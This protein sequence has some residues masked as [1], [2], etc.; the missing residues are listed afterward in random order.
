MAIFGRRLITLK[1]PLSVN[2]CAENLAMAINK[3]SLFFAN[4][5]GTQPVIGTIHEHKFRIRKRR[6]YQNSFAP[7]F[8]GTL[9]DDMT[10]TLIEGHFSMHPVVKGFLIFWFA[11]VTYAIIGGIQGIA[12]VLTDLINFVS[13]KGIAHSYAG[14]P[15]LAFMLLGGIGVILIGQL[16]G[17]SEKKYLQEFLERTLKAHQINANDFNQ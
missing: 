10:G 9:H 15:I 11:A 12:I 16:F 1:S 17:L 4:W 7:L 2:Q 14:L 5:R 3:E 13:G 8:Y 6:T